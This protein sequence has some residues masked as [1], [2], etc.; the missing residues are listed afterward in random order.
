MKSSID[1]NWFKYYQDNPQSDRQANSKELYQ[2]TQVR[3]QQ[4][5]ATRNQHL[6]RL[7]VVI[8]EANPVKFLAAFLAGVIAEVDLFLGDIAWQQREWEQVLSLVNPDLVFT[9]QSTTQDLINRIR[10]T[11]KNSAQRQ[12]NL[13]DRPLI[14]IPTGG[15]SGKIRLA[16]HTWDTLT[17]SVTGFQNYFDCQEIN[18]F[19]TLPLYHVSGLMQFMR[20]FTTQGNLIICSYKAVKTKQI[21][22][23]KQEYFISLV[24]T[25]LQFLIATIPNWLTEFG[26]VL[27]G[28]APPMRS[29]LDA[30]REYNISV[31][32]TYGMTETASGVVILKPLDFLAGNNSS[33]RVLPHAQIKLKPVNEMGLIEINCTSL[34]LGYYPQLFNSS[35]PFITDDIGYFDED[36]YLYLSGRNSHKIITGGENVFPAEVEAAIWSTKLVKDVCVLGICDR[37]WGQ[38]VTAI[39]VPAQSI[40]DLALIKEKLQSQLATYKQPKHW[41]QVDSLPRNDRGKINNQKLKALLHL[42]N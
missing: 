37:K 35:Q 9:S 14:M 28:G 5:A 26:T 16:M 32:A 20:S 12:S 17:A 33:G 29:L 1:R 21:T 7:A 22:F 8:V 41:I 11:L 30:A 27:L 15:T 13:C 6:T 2:L 38:A 40:P 31:A 3:L 36:G 25:Q 34:C 23:N 24:P 10:A 18:S 19:C 42:P 39:Y 4:I